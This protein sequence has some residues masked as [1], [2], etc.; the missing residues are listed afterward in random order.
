M[1]CPEIT[2]RAV[3]AAVLSAVASLAACA[4]YHAR[5]LDPAVSAH[6]LQ[7]RNLSDPRLLRFIAVDLKR[8][9]TPVHWD[10]A[11]LAA[12]AVF[13]R[14]D[15]KIAA[16]RLAEAQ[17][18]Q[19]TAAEWPNPT[20][21]LAPTYDSTAITPSPWIVGPTITALIAAA[22]KRP[23]AIARARAQA[24]AAR[25]GLAIAAWQLRAQVRT[26]FVALW[27]ARR[28][29]ALSRHYASAA[30]ELV[31]VV[32]QRYHAGLVSAAA[33]TT[34]QLSET[35]AALSLAA[36]DRQER[37]AEAALAA[38]IGVPDHAIATA[39]ID[40]GELDHIAVPTGL[41][42][43]RR[44]AL[45]RRPEIRAALARYNAA[46]ASLRLAVA[47]Q[48]PDLTIGPG[49]EYDRGEN[50]FILSV[51]LPLPVFNQNQGPIAAARAARQ[52]AAAEFAQT[53]TAVLG[54]TEA[55]VTDW[56]ASHREA[57]RTRRLL[58]LARQ[59]VRSDQAMFKA[60]QIGRLRLAGAEVAGTQA[61]LGALAASVHERNALGRLEDA[62]HHSFIGAEGG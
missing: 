2:V 38:A 15:L 29:L 11:A 54:Q 50:K 14:P 31:A 57:Q 32:A 13:D 16:G 44:E 48:Y 7:A 55:A 62:F 35:Q 60:G 52:V 20:L 19:R 41:A 5:P 61:E 8:P 26:A 28:Q 1:Y 24:A 9:Q 39:P 46:Q 3:R 51:S 47:R 37:L 21:S 4:T 53:Q 45:I 56:Q 18:E 30:Q 22:A 27:A 12:A 17:A 59:T 40:I 43:L 6:A 34:Q 10:L 58:Q 36:A 33:L 49:Y 25:Q 42:G 23:A